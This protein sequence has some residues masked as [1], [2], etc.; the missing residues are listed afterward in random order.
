MRIR[1]MCATLLACVA[2]G[3]STGCGSHVFP[4]IGDAWFPF[5]LPVPVPQIIGDY[6]QEKLEKDYRDVPIMPPVRDYAPAFCQDPPSEYDIVRAMKKPSCGGKIPYLYEK[7]YSNMEFVIEKLVD[8]IDDCRF[9]PLLGP[10]QLHHCH[11]KVTIYFTN[12]QYSY[13]PFSF[14][15]NQRDVDVVYIDK[16][17]FHIC[18]SPEME[19]TPES[20]QD[21]YGAY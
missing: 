18:T 17:H 16:D 12:L 10:A 5:W 13:Y 4:Y 2:V 9:Y 15:V 19:A 21:I 3:M 11:Y 20:Y 8:S 6:I 7:H 1:Q 14:W